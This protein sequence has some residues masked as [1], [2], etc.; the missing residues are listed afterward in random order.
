[1][2]NI[3]EFS[4]EFKRDI[5]PLAKKYHTLKKS[6]E[7]LR[8]KLIKNPYLGDSYGS[9]MFKVRLAD[10]SK[11]AGKSGGFRVLYY[12]LEKTEQ[13]ITILLTNIFNKSDISTIK[14]NDALKRLNNII[15]EYKQS[16]KP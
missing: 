11:G 9:N 2:S 14:K 10:G 3:V 8:E 6:V 15:D 4:P 7:D 1:M 16:K 5:K 13:G 12:H